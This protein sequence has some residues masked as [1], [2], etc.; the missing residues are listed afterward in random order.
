MTSLSWCSHV[1]LSNAWW[2]WLLS[3]RQ[4]TKVSGQGT[5][6]TSHSN[7]S[8]YFQSIQNNGNTSIPQKLPLVVVALP[9]LPWWL[10]ALCMLLL[11]SAS[12][13]NESLRL[14]RKCATEAVSLSNLSLEKSNVVPNWKG[15][16]VSLPYFLVV[17]L[18]LQ[19]YTVKWKPLMIRCVH[20]LTGSVDLTVQC[21]I[22]FKIVPQDTT[23]SSFIL[24]K[25]KKLR[26]VEDEFGSLTAWGKKL[27]CSVSVRSKQT[28]AGWVLSFSIIWPPCKINHCRAL[29]SWALQS[30]LIN[31][32][33]QLEHVW[34]ILFN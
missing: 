31:D 19:C 8:P 5:V 10:T 27:L 14:L 2:G 26:I 1:L 7:Y 23:C 17:T 18:M 29:L 6:Y 30:V 33:I 15:N 9:R 24:Y 13:W 25:T 28:V 12:V 3:L 34:T 4:W 22:N 32:I 11:L 20:L 16:Y 21:Q